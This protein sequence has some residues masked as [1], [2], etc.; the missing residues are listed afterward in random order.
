MSL[1]SILEELTSRR[2]V[3]PAPAFGEIHVMEV[4]ELLGSE[5]PVGRLKLSQRLKIGEGSTRTILKHLR[6]RGIVK[7]TRKGYM[8][9]R[10]GMKIYGFLQ[11]H[12]LGPLELPKTNLAFGEYN[13]AFLVRG[14]AEAVR[15]GLEQRDAAV[16]V[17]SLG[18]LTL[19]YKGRRL[20]MPGA[21]KR[22]SKDLLKVQQLLTEKFGFEEGDVVVVGVGGSKR[23][24]E[25]GAKAALLETLRRLRVER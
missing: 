1:L 12:I 10:K 7:G 13:V 22:Y 11:E 8:L 5:S 15:L 20:I 25:L 21:E 2:E 24:A 16:R 23:S 6:V 3:G 19:V 9:T 17:G 14:A 18:A 4:I